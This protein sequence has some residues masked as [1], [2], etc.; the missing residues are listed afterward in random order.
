MTEVSIVKFD[1][2]VEV[3]SGLTVDQGIVFAA[4]AMLDITNGNVRIYDI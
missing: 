2:T 3:W 4:R 1:K